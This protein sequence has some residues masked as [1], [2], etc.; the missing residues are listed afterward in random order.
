MTNSHPYHGLL[1][2]QH[3]SISN[4]RSL[5]FIFGKLVL[6]TQH[7][8]AVLKRIPENAPNV[9][10]FTSYS[11]TVTMS[12]ISLVESVKTIIAPFMV[13]SVTC[14]IVSLSLF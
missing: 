5:G 7:Y 11:C 1:E 3:M 4:S 13:S 2:N 8:C 6:H 10:S 12:P 14:I 9:S